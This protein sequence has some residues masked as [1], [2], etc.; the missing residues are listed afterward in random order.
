M[1]ATL[2]AALLKEASYSSTTRVLHVTIPV[3]DLEPP[4][5]NY[6]RDISVDRALCIEGPL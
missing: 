5:L 1:L 2:P 6:S 4:E 3:R